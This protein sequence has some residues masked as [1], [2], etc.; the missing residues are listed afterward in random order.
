MPRQSKRKT[1][2]N[3]TSVPYLPERYAWI[4]DYCRKKRGCV[5]EYVQAWDVTRYMLNGKFFVVI[6]QN[7]AKES[8]I[9]L[10]LEPGYGHLLRLN[11]KEITPGYHMNKRHW[12]SVVLE[13]NVLESNV[14]D[15]FIKELIDESYNIIFKSLG[16]KAQA[17]I[18]G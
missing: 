8:I 6:M 14:S 18:L 17:A 15:E 12:N 11:H 9:T 1:S 10:K 5:S 3:K 2:K 13:S 7:P 4:D 16:K